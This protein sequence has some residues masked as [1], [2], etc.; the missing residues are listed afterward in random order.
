MGED[1]TSHPIGGGGIGLADCEELL[2]W[3]GNGNADSGAGKGEE[4]GLVGVVESDVEDF[5]GLEKGHHL[6]WAGHVGEGGPYVET[7]KS[8]WNKRH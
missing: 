7:Y 8:I 3:N 6:S 5:L 1:V 2:V 4:H